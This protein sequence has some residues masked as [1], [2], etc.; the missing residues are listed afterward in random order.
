MSFRLCSRAPRTR[1]NPSGREASVQFLTFASMYSL[2][3]Q[4]QGSAAYESK[5]AGRGAGSAR[6]I[7]FSFAE[8]M[9]TVSDS[10]SATERLSKVLCS[11]Q[12]LRTML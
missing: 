2:R 7:P 4:K 11:L 1:T 6:W 5:T 12:S 10:R 9:T 8:A 3:A